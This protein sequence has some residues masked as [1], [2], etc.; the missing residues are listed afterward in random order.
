MNT[1]LEV[2]AAS[3]GLRLSPEE[4]EWL[5]MALRDRAEQ[6][7]REGQSRRHVLAGYRDAWEPVRGD[8]A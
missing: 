3:L 4:L 7:V 2:L 6:K 1:A 5:S 8:A